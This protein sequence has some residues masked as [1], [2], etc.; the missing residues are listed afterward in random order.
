MVAVGLIIWQLDLDC[1]KCASA[2]TRMHEKRAWVSREHCAHDHEERWSE[3][4]KLCDVSACPCASHLKLT[5]VERLT[6]ARAL[7][8]TLPFP[9]LNAYPCDPDCAEGNVHVERTT[10]AV[11]DA[12]ALGSDAGAA[13][14]LSGLEAAA[15]EAFECAGM[16]LDHAIGEHLHSPRPVVARPA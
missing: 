4:E 8:R 16:L 1:V 12:L 7:L 3:A 2:C 13:T 11:W 6:R 14:Y 10:M 15:G 5:D 9:I